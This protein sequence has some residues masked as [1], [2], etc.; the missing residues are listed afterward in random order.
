[1]NQRGRLARLLTVSIAF[2]ASESIGYGRFPRDVL[3]AQTLAISPS[4]LGTL[5]T[6]G[7]RL[8]L[9]VLWRGKPG[10]FLSGTTHGASYSEASGK[11]TANINYGGFPLLLSFE[12]S[13]RTALIQ[14]QAISMPIGTN[15]ISVDKVDSPATPALLK[16]FELDP[17]DEPVD[18]RAG[19]LGQLLARSAPIVLFLQCDVGLPTENTN[20]MI[21]RVACDGIRG[22]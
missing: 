22:R 10:W 12:P 6:R 9:L 21:R 4:V 1:M 18:P 15:V 5:A 16:A 8:E 3:T 14:G 13:S 2:V 7:D 17:G 19:R 20:R 11:W